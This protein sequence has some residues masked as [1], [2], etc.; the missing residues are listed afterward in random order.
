[1]EITKLSAQGEV[2]IPQSLR[3]AHHWDAGQ[4]FIILEISIR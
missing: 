4:E 3:E 1:M 2:I